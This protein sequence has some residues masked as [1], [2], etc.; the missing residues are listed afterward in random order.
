MLALEWLRRGSILAATY[1]NV[2]FVLFFIG[3]VHVTHGVRRRY[4]AAQKLLKRHRA[5]VIEWRRH[6]NLQWQEQMVDLAGRGFTLDALMHFYRALATTF[7]AFHFTTTQMAEVAC[8]TLITLPGK[9]GSP[10]A[11]MR[12]GGVPTLPQTRVTHHWLNLIRTLLATI[13]AHAPGE[14]E[15]LHIASG[16]DEDPG[17]IE[18]GFLE[19]DK[20]SAT[21]WACAFFVDQ[22]R[23]SGTMCSYAQTLRIPIICSSSSGSSPS[24]FPWALRTFW[25]A[26]QPDGESQRLSPARCTCGVE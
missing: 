23:M 15:F 26:R 21:Y 19:A 5:Y 24:S 12:L 20:R 8:M 1:S 16:L 9:A 10:M 2:F 25:G 3:A 18:Q 4:A 7:P 14:T 11:G 17:Q 6:G 22:H 13:L